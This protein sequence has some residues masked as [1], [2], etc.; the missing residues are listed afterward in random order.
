MQDTPLGHNVHTVWL[1]VIEQALMMRD[2]Q[3]GKIRAAQ[4]V[5]AFRHD[6]Q[7]VDIQ[8]AIRLIEDGE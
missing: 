2:D 4:A 6:A 5:D 3:R 7:R 8:P 1:N